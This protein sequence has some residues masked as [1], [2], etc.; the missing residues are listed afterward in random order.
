MLFEPGS[1]LDALYS[2]VDTVLILYGGVKELR[3]TGEQG[4]SEEDAARVKR[5]NPVI[6][7][8]LFATA[9]YTTLFPRPVNK[10]I[11]KS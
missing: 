11:V 3:M 5:R 8:R 2:A 4:T 7:I 10:K 9:H 6:V 1:G